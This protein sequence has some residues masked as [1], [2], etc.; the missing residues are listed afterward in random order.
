MKIHH[1][2]GHELSPD[3]A[4]RWA[5]L[6]RRD[7]TFE[8]AF[9]HP[10]FTRAVANV[11][12][13]VEL[14]IIE[15]GGR[16]LGFFPFERASARLGVPVGGSLSDYHGIV[17]DK[18]L[19]PAFD[20]VDLL[21]ACGLDCWDFDH[22][23]VAQSLIVS[24]PR[25]RIESPRI[26]LSQ[27]F[28]A[29]ARNK[30]AAGSQFID[31][32]KYLERR[33]ARE[34]GPVRFVAQSSDRSVFDRLRQWKSA[35]Y[36]RTHQVDI[37][38]SDATRELFDILHHTQTGE[39]AGTLSA[40]YAGDQLVAAH[41]GL[42][43]R[44]CWHYW[45]PAYDAAFYRYSPGQILILKMAAGAEALGVRSIDLGAGAQPYKLRLATG[46]ALLS[47]GSLQQASWFSLTRTFRRS[48]V[49]L[50]RK[51]P[52][53]DSGRALLRRARAFEL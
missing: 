17:S 5:A 27:G 9:F 47:A 40:L 38:R 3:L 15:D 31:R 20:P 11:K 7:R 2:A 53:A 28:A 13:N 44:D 52:F 18:E 22:L 33:L 37:F 6:Q 39:F 42:R 23:P 32:A 21:R 41:F 10:E 34:A 30:S 50:A 48:L 12:S 43:S 24:N 16:A 29:Y 8:S 51:T 4:A 36:L 46:S 25:R 14:A 49:D 19:D 35:Q 45:F 1:I 26:D